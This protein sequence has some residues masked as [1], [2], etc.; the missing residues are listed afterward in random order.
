MATIHFNKL[1]EIAN[2]HLEV[3]D[4]FGDHFIELYSNRY[5]NVEKFMERHLR[6]NIAAGKFDE[7]IE[8][9]IDRSILNLKFN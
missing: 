3:E 9:A 1:A 8:S 2:P 6:A 5:K 4:D 7:E